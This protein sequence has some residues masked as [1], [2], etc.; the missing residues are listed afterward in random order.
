MWRE[1]IWCAKW[2]ISV[3]S[4]VSWSLSVEFDGV[5]VRGFGEFGDGLG[6]ESFDDGSGLSGDDAVGFGKTSSR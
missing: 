5:V 1:V 3:S 6:G 2:R 4:S